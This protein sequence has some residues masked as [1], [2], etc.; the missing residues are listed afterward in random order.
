M[1]RKCFIFK[2]QTQKLWHSLLILL[3]ILITPLYKVILLHII[4]TSLYKVSTYVKK[5]LVRAFRARSLHYNYKNYSNFY[6]FI[7]RFPSEIVEYDIIKIFDYEL[8]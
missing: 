5:T 4:M 1:R 3:H 6:F 7:S 8:C 2:L